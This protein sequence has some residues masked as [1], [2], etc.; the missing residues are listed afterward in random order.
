MN[1]T[2]IFGIVFLV[3]MVIYSLYINEKVSEK[4]KKI[5]N[6]D[7]LDENEKTKEINKIAYWYIFIGFILF[8]ILMIIRSSVLK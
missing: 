4:R 5:N 2:D 6:K 8:F 1:K 7:N 3:S